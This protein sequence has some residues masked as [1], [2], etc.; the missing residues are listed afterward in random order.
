M[1]DSTIDMG[2]SD[3]G[4]SIQ[5]P[6]MDWEVISIGGS[7]SDDTLHGAFDKE[8]SSS[9]RLRASRRIGGGTSRLRGRP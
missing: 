6:L 9:E 1:S 7:S 3:F 2:G 8:F 4:G 5:Q